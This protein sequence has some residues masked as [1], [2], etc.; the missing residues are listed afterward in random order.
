[1]LNL[2]F[3]FNDD[4]ELLKTKIHEQN[5]LIYQQ[6]K[7]ICKQND[8]I[9]EIQSENTKLK[10][11]ID[12]L[13]P[14]NIIS[15]CDYLNENYNDVNILEPIIDY[16]SIVYEKLNTKLHIYVGDFI[17][18]SYK[19]SNQS[20]WYNAPNYLIRECIDNKLIWKIDKKGI[21]MTAIIINP[22]VE[23]IKDNI[24]KYISIKFDEMKTDIDG[25]QNDIILSKINGA[26]M[27]MKNIENKILHKKIFN[28]VSPYF[29]FN[30]N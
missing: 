24:A 13:K 6:T 11:S 14:K 27:E 18:K 29:L 9:N 22:I 4:L 7:L 20:I 2:L 26:M 30:Q 3:G 21:K 1:M 10:L 23:H 16:S 28:Y 17:V 25:H 5:N 15:I 12:K 19:K 8:V